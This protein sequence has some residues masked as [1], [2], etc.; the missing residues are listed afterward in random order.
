V[1]RGILIVS[2][3]RYFD[4]IQDSVGRGSEWAA[5]FRRAWGLDPASCQFRARGAAALHLY[6]LS[7][8]MFDELLPARHREVVER[9]LQL[10]KDAGY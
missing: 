5:A 1:Q 6:C 7:A 10:I 8:A 9:S 2:E 4:L 3:K